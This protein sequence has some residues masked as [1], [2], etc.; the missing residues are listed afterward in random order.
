MKIKKI[1]KRLRKLSVEFHA[2]A[3]NYDGETQADERARLFTIGDV[4]LVLANE[5]FTSAGRTSTKKRNDGPISAV[6]GWT[7]YKD[8]PLNKAVD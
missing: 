5:V 1:V 2:R 8:L 4:C 7:K 6:T 3:Q